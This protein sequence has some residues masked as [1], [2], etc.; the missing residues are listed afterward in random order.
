RTLGALA[1]RAEAAPSAQAVYHRLDRGALQVVEVLTLLP[2]PICV[3]DVAA[4]LAP[5][6]GPADVERPLAVLES[7][8]LVVRDG[9][10]VT[11]NPGL[12]RLPY[13]ARLGPPIAAP[14]GA[15]AATPLADMSRRPGVQPAAS[16]AASLADSP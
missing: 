11:L 16:K 6:V 15:Q 1:E 12:S 7:L 14:P 4:M 9:E 5:G 10:L 3:H 8:A 2:P 13:R